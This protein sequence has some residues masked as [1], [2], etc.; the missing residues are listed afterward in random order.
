MTSVTR[1]SVTSRATVSTGCWP[2]RE[3]R[4]WGR[5]S[6]VRTVALLLLSA[7]ARGADHA[8]PAAMTTM[9]AALQTR[10]PDVQIERVLPS[11]VLPGMYDVITD[12]DVLYV[13]ASMRHVIVG[14][15]FQTDSGD[16]LTRQRWDDLHPVA[17]AQ[18]PLEQAVKWVRGSGARRV[19]VFADPLCPYC[20]QLEQTL[21]ALDDVT[22][23]VFLMPLESIHPGATEKS[24]RIWCANDRG[25]AWTAWMLRSQEPG[26]P[27]CT[28]DPLSAVRELATKLKVGSTPTIFFADGL[29]ATG[30]PDPAA[31]AARLRDAA[32]RT[33]LA[34]A[35]IAQ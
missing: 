20:R 3:G 14:R 23:Y 15:V 21:Q 29:R 22:V 9:Q 7:A 17:F 34:G 13:D 5:P 1:E 6:F 4:P 26:A 16:N 11:S 32:D 33:S 35:V 12:S 31:L 25:S 18:L 30:A 10:L 19:A 24:R 2:H 28:A 8:D 27:T